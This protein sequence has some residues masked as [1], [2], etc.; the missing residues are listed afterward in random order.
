MRETMPPGLVT[1]MAGQRFLVLLLLAAAV[2]GGAQQVTS[3]LSGTV[4]DTS[5]AAVPQVAVTATDVSTQV[6]TRT[7]SDEAGRYIFPSLPTG[8]YNLSAEKSGFQRT[9]LPGITLTVYQKATVDV[10]LQVGRVTQ[11]VEVKGAAPLLSTSSAS[12]GTVIEEREMVDL[13][14]NL[15]RTSSLALLVP[16]VSDTSGNSLTSANGNGSGF[17]TTSFS[18]AGG[19]SSSNLVLV[20]GMPNRALNNGGFALDLPPEMVKEF[21]IQNNIYDA[22]Y[23]VAAGAVMNTITQSGTNQFH[24]SA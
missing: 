14:L 22:A 5:G 18:A 7:T 3:T 4:S 16:A 24:G 10:V 1:A 2:P 15:R 9:V 13:P 11:A 8:T 21:N 19:A 6:A 12:I 20:D 23:G 17:N